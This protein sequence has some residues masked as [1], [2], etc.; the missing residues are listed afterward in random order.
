M[1]SMRKLCM[2]CLLI[3]VLF[4][5]VVN[6][7]AAAPFA[8]SINLPVTGVVLPEGGSALFVQPME[9]AQ[10]IATLEE[11]AAVTVE[12]LGLYWCKVSDGS[13]TGYIPTTALHLD[14]WGMPNDAEAAGEK[15]PR[16]AVFN[17]GMDPS[18]NW[19]MTLREQASRKGKKM[20]TITA[21][22]VMVVLEK[23][24]EFSLVHV[25]DK[26]GYLLTKYL[27][28][29][30]TAQEAPGYA[31]INNKEDV[32]FRFDRRF[33]NTGII[34]VLHPGDV[35]TLIWEKKGWACVEAEGY[36][37]YVVSDYI[38]VVKQDEKGMT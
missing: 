9:Q 12:S 11:G 22:A 36:Q 18:G 21:G 7:Q 38:H 17:V 8:G 35:M 30:D 32:N 31:I 24:N 27:T 26:V 33:G 15:A 25:G 16:L 14:D 20:D 3:L 10:A 2:T 5:I 13:Q 6:A 1:C 4:G 37:G 34:M 23:N 29:Y 28:F 19:S